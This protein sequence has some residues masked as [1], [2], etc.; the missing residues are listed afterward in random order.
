MIQVL[1]I[2][3][4]AIH[5]SHW[6]GVG[7]HFW[8]VGQILK[9]FFLS[10]PNLIRKMEYNSCNKVMIFIKIQLH[11]NYIPLYYKDSLQLASQGL[12]RYDFYYLKCN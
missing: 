6:I 8:R 2:S 7:Q 5:L 11:Y 4:L 12:K 3:L 10:R 9:T 1:Y